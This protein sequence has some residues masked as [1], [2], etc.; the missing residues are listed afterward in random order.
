[1]EKCT[2]KDTISISASKEKEG[3]LYSRETVVL[4]YNFERFKNEHMK[5]C[6]ENYPSKERN[7]SSER[8]NHV[9]HL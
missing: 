4:I 3:Q 1:M 9:L 5:I 8:S 2:L 6:Y 7:I